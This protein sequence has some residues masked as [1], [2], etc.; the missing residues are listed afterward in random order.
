MSSKLVFEPGGV[1]HKLVCEPV[2][3]ARNA[4]PSC[5]RRPQTRVR[6]GAGGGKQLCR[7]VPEAANWCASQGG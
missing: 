3:E 5:C 7:A 2:P 6:A 4:C 1:G